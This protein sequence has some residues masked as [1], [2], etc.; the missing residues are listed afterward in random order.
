MLGNL[1]GW[2]FLIVLV[3]VLLLFGA[4]KL[5]A[6]AR[7]V[8]QSM[9]IFRNEIK[10]DDTTTPEASKAADDDDQKSSDSK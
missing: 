6:L 3:V 5:P 8:G 1:S 2:H 10:S 4:T 7:S 9:K